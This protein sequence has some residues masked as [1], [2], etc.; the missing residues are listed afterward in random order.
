[1]GAFFVSADSKGVSVLTF[2]LASPRRRLGLGAGNTT[3]ITTTRVPLSIN[4]FRVHS[5][6]RRAAGGRG[7]RRPYEDAE[8]GAGPKTGHYI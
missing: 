5:F 4:Y 1:M 3:K 8:R 7:K 2:V 6:E